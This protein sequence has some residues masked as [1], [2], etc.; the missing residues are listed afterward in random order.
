MLLLLHELCLVHFRLKQI[1]QFVFPLK[2]SENL[3]AKFCGNPLH[4]GTHVKTKLRILID[5]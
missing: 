4:I 1:K 3:E 2:L 5:K